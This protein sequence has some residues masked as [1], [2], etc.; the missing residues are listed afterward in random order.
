MDNGVEV[1]SIDDNTRMSVLKQIHACWLIG[2]YD[3]LRNK[4]NEAN[5]N[6]IGEMKNKD[7]T[8]RKGFETAGIVEALNT[9]LEPEDPSQDID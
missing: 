7:N 1:Y 4:F 6:T 5:R 9:E 3:Y 8:I 2:L